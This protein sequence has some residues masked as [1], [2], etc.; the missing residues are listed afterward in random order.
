MTI[1][2]KN[3]ANKTKTPVL[4]QDRGEGERGY[5]KASGLSRFAGIRP[6]NTSRIR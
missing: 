2:V 4:K 5:L 1:L 3:N 6:A